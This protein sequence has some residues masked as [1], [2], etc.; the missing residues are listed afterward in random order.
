MKFSSEIIKET[1]TI[2]AF[3]CITESKSPYF[4]Y[5]SILLLSVLGFL[6]KQ[7]LVV[8]IIVYLVW[9]Y[10]SEIT[11]E[12]LTVIKG[13]GVQITKYRRDGGKSN[14]FIDCSDIRE[15]II[16]EALTPYHVRVCLGIIL[17]KSQEL[18]V[19]FQGFEITLTQAKQVYQAT[20]KILFN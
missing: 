16:N 14:L 6:L 3:S 4:L 11:Q 12:T 7:C 9:G 13:I 2:L 20:R 15:V 5:S 8:V 10:R 17:I 1:G 19:P 18:I